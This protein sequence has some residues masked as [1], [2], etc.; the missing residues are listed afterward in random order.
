MLKK[1][2][3]RLIRRF[4]KKKEEPAPVWGKVYYVNGKGGSDDDDG[5]NPARPLRTFAKALSLYAENDND[6]IVVF[7]EEDEQCSRNYTT[8]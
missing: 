8:G 7:Q 6:Q 5:L 1:L 4:I 2:R 3:G